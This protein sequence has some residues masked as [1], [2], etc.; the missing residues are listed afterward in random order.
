VISSFSSSDV[1]GNDDVQEIDVGK[2]KPNQTAVDDGVNNILETVGESDDQTAIHYV[3]TGADGICD[4]TKNNL[5]PSGDDDQVIQV[6]KGKADQ[7]CVSP[8][9]NGKRDTNKSGNDEF[10][11][12]SIHT[13]S[14]GICNTTANNTGISPDTS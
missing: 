14:D 12:E 2:G 1:E 5:I 10:T 6:G 9:P 4:T 8:G 3:T 11:G 7:I 13:G